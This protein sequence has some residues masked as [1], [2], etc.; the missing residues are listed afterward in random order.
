[1]SAY[2]EISNVTDLKPRPIIAGPACLTHRLSNFID[3]LLRPYTKHVRSNLRD[4]T[5]FL[6]N[7]PKYVPPN[8]LLVSFDIETLYSN[9]PHELGMEAVKQWLETYPA[10]RKS[11]RFSNDFIIKGI[12][13]IFKN[14]TFSFG[15]NFYNKTKVQQWA[16]SSHL[17]MQLLP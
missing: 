8:T 13:F 4:T 3:I 2:I 17:Y 7:L 10:E 1:M 15:D 6:N 12:Q 14:N 5:D 9:I 11:Q 16:R